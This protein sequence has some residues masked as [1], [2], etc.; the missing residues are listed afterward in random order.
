MNKVSKKPCRVYKTDIELD[1]EK[2]VVAML[3]HST[4][5]SKHGTLLEIKY[6]CQHIL[7]ASLIVL[8]IPLD[9]IHQTWQPALS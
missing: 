6:L 3:F 1:R 5:F 9:K 4:E 8:I 7:S 2:E